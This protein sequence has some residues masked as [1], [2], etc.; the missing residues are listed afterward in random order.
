MVTSS[1]FGVLLGVLIVRFNH[2]K[3]LLMGTLC[4]PIGALGCSI[5]PNFIFLQIFYAIE[6]IGT[7]I[8]LVVTMVLVGELVKL[9]KRPQVTGWILGAPTLGTVAGSF[10]INIFFGTP[11]SWRSFLL[12]WALPIS[13]IAVAAAYFVVPS[14]PQKQKETTGNQSF[15]RNFK[16]IFL[17]KSAAVCLIA[18]T[19]RAV[20]LGWGYYYIAFL[21]TKFSLSIGTGALAGIG[22]SITIGIG[23]FAGGYLVNRTGRKR[24]TVISLLIHGFTLPLITLVPDLLIVLTILYSGTFIGSFAMPAGLNLTLE[25]VPESRGTMMSVNNVLTTL[26]GGISTAIGGLT[27]TLFS[28]TGLFFTF[29]GLIIISAAIFFFVKDPCK[30]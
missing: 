9:N 16:Q 12:W 23:H 14:T 29:A 18:N 5:A 25:Q 10:V 7:M 3:L 26:A 21:I 1:I 20:S 28:Y 2:K 27:L 8:V 22:F 11:G 4:A 19:V 13:L 17:I 30:I 24:L 6:G 15:F